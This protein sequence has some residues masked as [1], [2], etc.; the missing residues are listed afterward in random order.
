MGVMNMKDVE[1]Q[2]IHQ[3]DITG[4]GVGAIVTSKTVKMQGVLE[5][6]GFSVAKQLYGDLGRRGGANIDLE[7]LLED[8]EPT[9]RTADMR[10]WLLIEAQHISSKHVD[11]QQKTI[12]IPIE[13][14]NDKAFLAYTP[15]Y[16]SGYTYLM[17]FQSHTDKTKVHALR[18]VGVFEPSQFDLAVRGRFTHNSLRDWQV[19]LPNELGK[20]IQAHMQSHRVAG[21]HKGGYNSLSGGNVFMNS[22]PN[23]MVIKQSKRGATHLY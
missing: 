15:T 18:I 7:H 13:A 6:E 19:K 9:I 12:T 4:N 17:L 22:A 8:F 1:I 23:R 10:N 2:Y 14:F 3:E 20:Y 21:V 16:G 11:V 5:M